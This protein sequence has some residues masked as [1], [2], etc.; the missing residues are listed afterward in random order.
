[1]DGQET[2]ERSGTDA[3]P[4]LAATLSALIPGAGQWYAGRM[5]LAAP[6][7]LLLVAVLVAGR[8][9]VTGILELAV[10]PVVLWA[11][12][13]VNA[14]IL[15]W[16]LF[17]VIDAYRI[18]NPAGAGRLS[19]AVLIVMGVLVA[20][21]HVIAGGYGFRGVVL[22]DRVFV[23]GDGTASAP[24]T[25]APPSPEADLVPDRG[26]RRNN[27]HRAH[28]HR[29]V[30]HGAALHNDHRGR[31]RWKPDLPTGFR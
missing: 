24:V 19:V 21:P 12:L 10:Q 13:G 16:R 6:L 20:A 9:G 30:V 22:I 31:A 3:N 18:S 17:A 27:D 2:T 4:G 26:E 28:I 15:A 11:L 5:V 29:A 7:L 8:G 25:L 23:S 1:M 14:V